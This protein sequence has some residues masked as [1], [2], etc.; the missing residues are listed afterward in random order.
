MLRA[1]HVCIGVLSD[2]PTVAVAALNTLPALP[3]EGPV[4]HPLA[5]TKCFT[6]L[7]ENKVAYPVIECAVLPGQSHSSVLHSHVAG[8]IM[9][10]YI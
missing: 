1:C 2:D 4:D 10:V 5:I 3:P 9:Y 7:R 6:I 8:G